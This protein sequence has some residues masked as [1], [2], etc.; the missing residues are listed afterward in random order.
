MCFWLLPVKIQVKYQ[1]LLMV[2]QTRIREREMYM[3][4]NNRSEEGGGSSEQREKPLIMHTYSIRDN[5]K[6]KCK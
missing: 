6:Y 5:L 1:V 3:L 4:K 2:Q